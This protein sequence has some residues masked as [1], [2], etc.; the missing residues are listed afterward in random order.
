LIL[1][2]PLQPWAVATYPQKGRAPYINIRKSFKEI[3]LLLYFVVLLSGPLPDVGLVI[4]C[5]KVFFRAPRIPI[6]AALFSLSSDRH[7]V[8][9]GFSFPF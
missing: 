4:F 7:E 5:A 9:G 3:S 1:Y 2:K 8:R 6:L